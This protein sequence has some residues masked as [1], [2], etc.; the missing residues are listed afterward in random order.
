MLL[1]FNVLCTII[2]WNLFS[3]IFYL[4]NKPD[5]LTLYCGI[6]GYSGK[7]VFNK[8]K[9]NQLALL[10]SYER[11]L[12]ATGIYSPANGLVKNTD[13]APTFLVRNNI[14]QDYMLMMHVRHA[15]VGNK[16][17][18]ENAHPFKYGNVTL[19][20]NGTLKNHWDL[21]IKYGFE[22]K[23]FDVDSQVVA[24]I[25]GKENT[26]NVISE[27]DG[28]AAFLINNDNTPNI[29]YAYRN[30]ERPL[31][32]GH[33]EDDMYISSIKE[34]LQMIGCTK[35][36]EFKENYIY[37]IENGKIIN[38]RLIK[39]SPYYRF[40]ASKTVYRELQPASMYLNTSLKLK[41]CGYWEEKYLK[42]DKYYT[43]IGANN[44]TQR[45]MVKDDKGEARE[46]SKFDFYYEDKCIIDNCFVRTSCDLIVGKQTV[47]TEGE[48]FSVIKSNFEKGTVKAFKLNDRSLVITIPKDLIERVDKDEEEYIIE[49]YTPK[50]EPQLS[51]TF[52]ESSQ[53]PLALN[54]LSDIVGET[55]IEE[56]QDDNLVILEQQKLMS[57]LSEID[58]RVD[59]M[60]GLCRDK[61][62]V[63]DLKPITE[64]YSKINGILSDLSYKIEK[65]KQ[66]FI[67]T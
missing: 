7:S 34:G 36:K 53:E 13:P 46:V 24:G 62:V 63:D 19:L 26:F 33:I 40:E 31:F 39:K 18:D 43:V 59:T 66:T 29:L 22:Y 64:E 47:A 11:G 1:I 10:N 37:A 32:R 67:N 5:K 38:H 57:N 17:K 28:P 58:N 14:V 9:I 61:L 55:I 54:E 30:S 41:R 6:I 8:D 35:I 12:D 27:I 42:V 52:I 21:T 51:L 49:T 56:E 4:K 44:S 20:H 45:F 15:T 16:A 65:N 2:L 3:S 60:Y 23:N 50:N 48:Y 25:I